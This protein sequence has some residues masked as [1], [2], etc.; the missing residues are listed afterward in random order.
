MTASKDSKSHHKVKKKTSVNEFDSL[1]TFV[2]YRRPSVYEIIQ[3]IP[4][5]D[6]MNNILSITDEGKTKTKIGARKSP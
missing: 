6:Q 2:R 3:C 4:E 5:G 1:D